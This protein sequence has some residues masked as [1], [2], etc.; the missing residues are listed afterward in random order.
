MSVDLFTEFGLLPELIQSIEQMGFEQPTP[1]QQVAIPALLEGRNVIAQAQ[2]GTG[3]T[4][5]FVLPMLQQLT[6]VQGTVQALILAPTRELAVQVSTAASQM[7]AGMD[8]RVLPV[9]GGQSYTVQKTQLKRGVD[10]VVGTPGRLLDLIRQGVLDLSQVRYLVIDEADEMLEMGFIEDVES[11]L[12]QLP[13]QRQMALFSATLPEVVRKLGERFME[14][15]ARFNL[16]PSRPT[17]EGI[18]QRYY[19]V[20]DRDKTA[21]LIRLLEVEDL[22]QGLIF[23]RTKAR[24]QELADELASR[25]LAVEALH[26]DLNQSRGE[27][28]LNRFRRQALTLVVATDVAARGLDIEAVSH[29]FNYDVPLDPEDYVHRIGRTGRAGRTGTAITFLAPAERRRLKMIESYIRQP[30]QE[31]RVPSLEE[32]QARRDERFASRLSEMAAEGGSEAE[33]ALVNR[34]MES[35][36]DPVQVALAAI[37]MARAGEAALPAEELE[38]VTAEKR[39]RREQRKFTGREN[40]FEKRAPRGRKYE[41][42][43]AYPAQRGRG[44][45]REPGMVRLWMNLGGAQGVRPGDVVGAIA[46]EVGIPGRAIGEIDIRR[47]H[48]FVD[49]SEQHVSRVLAE[50]SGKYSLRGRPVTLK[51]AN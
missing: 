6:P 50:S 10:V 49:V 30:I 17:V 39:D 15:P 27:Y 5:A 18:E 22:T 4:A 26:G 3:K 44:N 13:E 36:L 34:L 40:A 29:V 35:G 32:L 38:P 12:D 31:H 7:A 28:V 45:H 19:M 23:A 8:L 37:R 16:S 20:R 42:Q 21:A 43:E 11:I 9:Y 33:M 25:G 46:S 24:A 51:L 14:N 1:V 41:R 2:T 47:D 48:T